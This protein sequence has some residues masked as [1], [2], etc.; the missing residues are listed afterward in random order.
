MLTMAA[1]CLSI[2]EGGVRGIVYLL[3][4]GIHTAEE[5]LGLIV[6]IILEC[7]LAIPVVLA[8]FYF[9]DE[10]FS[11]LAFHYYSNYSWLEYHCLVEKSL[12]KIIVLMT[13]PFSR[14]ALSHSGRAPLTSSLAVSPFLLI[15]KIQNGSFLSFSN[16]GIE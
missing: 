14:S 16:A 10:R 8:C 3:P 15:L 5:V 7:S 11:N 4:E 9:A 1:V 13:L 2:E 12:E 6:R